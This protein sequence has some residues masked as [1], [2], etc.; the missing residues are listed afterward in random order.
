MCLPCSSTCKS[1]SGVA[2]NCLECDESKYTMVDG[3]CK[4][5]YT[6]KMTF[7]LNQNY[8]A[9]MQAGSIQDVIEAIGELVDGLVE[10]PD[11]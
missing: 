3:V 5:R 8:T 6:A 11:D 7:E 10:N 1:C 4:G 2:T 9:F